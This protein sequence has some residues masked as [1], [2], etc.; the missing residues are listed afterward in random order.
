[1]FFQFRQGTN[2]YFDRL[3]A[4]TIAM[5]ALQRRRNASRQRDVVVLDQYAVGQVKPVVLPTSA[6]DGVFVD[7]AKAG[8]GFARVQNAGLGAGDGIHKSACVRRHATHALQ[9]IQYDALAGENHAR[10]VPD[11]RNGLPFVQSNAIENLR[12][13]RDFVVGSH[14]A[15]ECGINIQNPACAADPRQNAILLGENGGGSALVGINAGVA[16]GVARGAILEER[17]LQNRRKSPAIPVHLVFRSSIL[18]VR[19][20]LSRRRCSFVSKVVSDAW[21]AHYTP[22]GANRTIS[23][24]TSDERRKN[25][26]PTI[27]P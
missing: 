26:Q 2:L 19:C 22:N 12:V 9:E 15:I 10:I 8:N 25:G 18:V 3:L 20:L 6:A 24:I 1:R 11:H 17:I 7:P 5:G 21:R 23:S 4:T 14:G 16:G 13:S 27:L